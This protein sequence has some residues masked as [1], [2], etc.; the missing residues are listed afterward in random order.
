MIMILQISPTQF[1]PDINEILAIINNFFELSF[2]YVKFIFAGILLLIGALTLLSL[3]GRFFLERLRY[4]KEEKLADNPLTKPRLIIGTIYII[5]GFGII[6]NWFTYFLIFILNP[7]PDRFIFIYIEFTGIFDPFYLNRISDIQLA[8]LEYEKTIYY[9]LAIFSFLAIL[10]IL[11][12]IRQLVLGNGKDSRK[13]I[14]AMIGGIMMGILVGFTTCLP[15]F[16]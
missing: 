11:L 16:L 13:A 6:F 12:S 9:G 7:L 3:R 14:I 15:L 1:L 8:Q 5:L 2:F 10:S 4:S